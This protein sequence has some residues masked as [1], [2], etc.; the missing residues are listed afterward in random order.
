MCVALAA[1]LPAVH[2]SIDATT[3]ITDERPI[4]P[5]P[6]VQ[7]SGVPV[8]GR[9]VKQ[10]VL[11]QRFLLVMVLPLTLETRVFLR[12]TSRYAE[13][14]A[15]RVKLRAESAGFRTCV[16]TWRTGREGSGDRREIDC[17]GV[18][19]Y[20]WEES[21]QQPM[22]GT[23]LTLGKRRFRPVHQRAMRIMLPSVAVQGHAALGGLPRTRT[24]VTGLA[25]G[26]CQRSV[27]P[28][29]SQRRP[30]MLRLDPTYYYGRT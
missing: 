11:R 1:V 23:S 15:W 3:T 22:T 10:H 8:L 21:P 18:A 4:P 29:T 30:W 2:L 26:L 19:E 16:G 20:T 13:S 27:R 25:A 7:P 6:Q 5:C 28:G 9:V 14:N 12:L 24:T 17:V